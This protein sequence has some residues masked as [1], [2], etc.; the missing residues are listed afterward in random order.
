MKKNPKKTKDGLFSF[1]DPILNERCG[2]KAIYIS[3]E[4]FDKLNALSLELK[5]DRSALA[6]YFMSLG[7]NTTTHC[8]EQSVVFDIEEVR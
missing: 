2:R 3:K 8:P 4:I 1:N 6:D 7:V 5:K